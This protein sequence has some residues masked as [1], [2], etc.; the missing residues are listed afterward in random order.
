[1]RR[2]PIRRTRDGRYTVSLGDEERALLAALS[3][4]MREVLQQ[5]EDPAL[6]RLFP[7]AYAAEED[8]ALQEEYHR[9]M[10]EDLLARHCEALDVLEHSAPAESLTAEQLDGWLRA[11][12]SIRLLLG[13]RLDVSEEDDPR[14]QR[15]PEHVLYYFLGY[16]QECA[17]DAMA[18]DG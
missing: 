3:G 4:Q 16:L 9:L 12:N 2:R 13:T 8:K 6:R 14:L 5:P 1:L 7:P 15:D 10:G 11:L 18:G 17:L